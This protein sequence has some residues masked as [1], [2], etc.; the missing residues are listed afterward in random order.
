MEERHDERHGL[1]VNGRYRTGKGMPVDIVLNDLSRSGCQIHDRLGRLEV[2][3]FMTIRIGP[4]GP[5]DAHVRWLKGRV[6]GIQFDP[7]LND[8][9]LDHLRTIAESAPAGASAA[10]QDS[11]PHVPEVTRLPL[12][13]R[14]RKFAETV[15]A[16]E[17]DPQF[18]EVLCGLDRQ[19]SEWLIRWRGETVHERRTRPSYREDIFVAEQMEET[20]EL[21]RRKRHPF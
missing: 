12:A 11:P 10:P 21:R 8:A 4:I 20:H 3:Q 15:G 6:A 19:E 7:P 14:E 5:I 13:K 1:I 2:D 16:L 18:R 17:V 9:V